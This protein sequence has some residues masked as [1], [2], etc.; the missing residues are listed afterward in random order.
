MQSMLCCDSTF[1][2]FLDQ[3]LTNTN[4]IILAFARYYFLIVLSF[5]ESS[6][7]NDGADIAFLIDSSGSLTPFNY[8]N[9][10]SFVKE[11]MKELAKS[12]S[13]FNAAVLAFSSDVFAV[14]DFSQKFNLKL[15]NDIVDDLPHLQQFTRMDKALI[16]TSDYIF[17][18]LTG[19]RPEVSKIVVLITDGANSKFPGFVP[20]RNASEPLKQ[21]GV[22]IFVVGDIRGV[23]IQELLEITE[24]EDDLILVKGFPLLSEFAGVL[25]DKVTSAIGKFRTEQIFAHAFIRQLIWDGRGWVGMGWCGIRY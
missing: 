9:E 16:Y 4:E 7:N 3:P 2:N 22:R 12:S 8:Q 5:S 23:D 6:L 11:V 14:L 13:Q 1:L 24:R 15:F 18:A 25:V 19:S 21:K 17:T 10:K 20:L